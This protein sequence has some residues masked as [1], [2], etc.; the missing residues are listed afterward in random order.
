VEVPVP[1]AAAGQQDPVQGA[2]PLAN[3][4]IQQS[5]VRRV[6]L[7]AAQSVMASVTQI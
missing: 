4:L 3:G 5:H 1:A 6:V 7:T 2:R